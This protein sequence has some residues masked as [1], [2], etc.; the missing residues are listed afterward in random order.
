MLEDGMIEETE[1]LLNRG[2]PASSPALKRFGLSE[3]YRFLKRIYLKDECPAAPHPRHPPIRQT[4]NDLVPP[5]TDGQLEK[6][7]ILPS[8]TTPSPP[9]KVGAQSLFVLGPGFRRDDGKG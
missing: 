7:V 6:P 2:L 4:P 1:A 5:S 3:N 8:P 9:T